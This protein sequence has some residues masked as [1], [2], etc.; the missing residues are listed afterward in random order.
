MAAFAG[1]LSKSFPI[2]IAFFALGVCYHVP[3]I[4]VRQ[5]LS[6]RFWGEGQY[7]LGPL[8]MILWLVRW[9]LFFYLA[10]HYVDVVH[11]RYR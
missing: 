4:L 5:A 7:S 11:D 10:A 9:G 6:A 1:G 2:A 8:I 3:F